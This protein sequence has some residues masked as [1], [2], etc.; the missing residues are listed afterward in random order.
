M[1]TMQNMRQNLL[2][3]AVRKR[4]ISESNEDSS[5]YNKRQKDSLDKELCRKYKEDTKK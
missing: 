5:K 3:C 4:K 2:I 1:L